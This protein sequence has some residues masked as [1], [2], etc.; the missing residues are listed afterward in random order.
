MLA[1]CAC[2]YRGLSQI[3]FFLT[4]GFH[5]LFFPTVSV[6]MTIGGGGGVSGCD[7]NNTSSLKLSKEQCDAKGLRDGG[8]ASYLINIKYYIMYNFIIITVGKLFVKAP[9]ALSIWR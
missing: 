8:L 7:A 1:Y 3:I 2:P 9:L 6:T 4:G 5:N